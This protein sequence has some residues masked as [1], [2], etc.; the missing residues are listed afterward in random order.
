MGLEDI[1]LVEEH[2]CKAKYHDKEHFPQ[3]FVFLNKPTIIQKWR[4]LAG[5]NL[6]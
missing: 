3:V 1:D 4:S 6:S 5:S 2:S